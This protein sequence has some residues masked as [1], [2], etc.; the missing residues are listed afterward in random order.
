MRKYIEKLHTRPIH[1]KREFAVHAAAG[2]T[3]LVFLVWLST[4]GVRMATSNPQTTLAGS[5]A[6]NLIAATAAAGTAFQAQMHE[7]QNVYAQSQDE[8]SGDAYSD[9]P[10][11]EQATVIT[12]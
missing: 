1:E 9:V 7:V 2:V 5:D 6:A 12:Q 8:T 11:T 4:L 3:A 10:A